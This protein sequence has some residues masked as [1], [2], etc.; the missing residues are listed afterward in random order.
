MTLV[1]R[2]LSGWS[3]RPEQR[4]TYQVLLEAAAQYRNSSGIPE[5]SLRVSTVYACV[6]VISEALAQLPLELYRKAADGGRTVAASERI[7]RTLHDRP[8]K[9]QTS[10]EFRDM[11]MMHVLL[12]GNSFSEIVI[13]RGQV[14]LRPIFPSRVTKIEKRVDGSL[15]YHVRMSDNTTKPYFQDEIFHV[16][17]PSLDGIIG[18]TPIEYHRSI[19]ESSKSA[20]DH[21]A[22]VWKNGARPSIVL[23]TEQSLPPNASERMR[24]DWERLYGGAENAGKTAVLENGL[25]VHEIG[26]NHA[27]LQFIEQQKF[28][29]RQI[30]S[31]FRVPLHMIGDLEHATFSNIEH[32][33]LEFVKYTMMPWLERWEQ[34]IQRDLIGDDDTLYAEFNVEGLLRGDTAARSQFYREMFNIGS[35]S[36]N[37]IRRYE[38]LNPVEGGDKYF[39]N[40]ALVELN[41]AGE[42][43]QNDPVET[44]PQESTESQP[45]D[46]SNA[47]EAA[48]SIWDDAVA[49]LIR[50][51]CDAIS[52]AAKEPRTFLNKCETFLEEHRNRIEQKLANAERMCR[53]VGV[54]QSASVFAAEHRA[55]VWSLIL[56][57]SEGQAAELATRV[58]AMIERIKEQHK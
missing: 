31:V 24:K 18:L 37:E 57:A 11:S 51:E 35:V 53:V 29:A 5:T 7:Y 10:I 6:R 58:D 42:D 12:R 22:A 40:A 26:L 19:I 28:N 23:Q 39:V 4:N 55:A 50:W 52:R 38:N 17:G 14:E 16:R 32:Q 54:E 30:A 2:V 56:E 25:K 46:N 15:V 49:S 43:S 21:A 34:A 20:D 48:R 9:W 36:V 45:V 33:G 27:D 44:M 8:N 41:H 47:Q 3:R 13:S 1:D